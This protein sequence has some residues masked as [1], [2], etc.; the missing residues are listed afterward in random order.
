[1]QCCGSDVML[2]LGPVPSAEW[3]ESERDVP[4]LP[5][6]ICLINITVT[7]SFTLTLVRTNQGDVNDK[8]TC[9]WTKQYATD[10]KVG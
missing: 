5:A 9:I 8:S 6:V 3:T 7:H 2:S 1:M 4:L 10:Y